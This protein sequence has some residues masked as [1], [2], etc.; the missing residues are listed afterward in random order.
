MDRDV[1]VKKFAD[2]T[3]DGHT[4]LFLGAGSSID[5]GYPSWDILF[6]PLFDKLKISEETN[7]SYYDIAQ[8]YANEFG[9][10]QL[11]KII[12][13]S[14]NSYNYRSPL[15][16]ELLNIDFNNIWTTNFDNV[17]ESNYRTRN[18]DVNVISRD[19]NLVNLNLNQKLNI[20][21][22]NGDIN[23]L[24]EI[25]STRSEYERYKELHELMIMF[26]KK[27]LISNTMLFLGYSFTDNLVIECIA[28]L[29][30]CVGNSMM[31]HYTIMKDLK[32]PL[33]NHFIDD[34]NKRYN[35]Q[36]ILVE[37]YEDIPNV[38]ADLNATIQSKKIFISGAYNLN[39]INKDKNI[40]VDF[41]HKLSNELSKQLL[42]EDYRI[43]NGI[44]RSFGTQL[45]GYANEYLLKHFKGNDGKRL[46]INPFV[47]N[48]K[49][50]VAIKNLNRENII[51]KCGVCIFV[52]GDKYDKP[53][54]KSGVMEEFEIARKEKKIIIPIFYE[55]MI[56]ADIWDIVN[57]H[58]TEFYYLENYIGNLRFEKGADIIVKTIIQILSNCNKYSSNNI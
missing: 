35:I 11:K 4:S 49:D 58:K 44:G 12:N 32:T 20:F 16:D 25:I 45:I 26:L 15:H 42:K 30:K 17:I 41:S 27:E 47:S 57:N 50:S 54:S 23:N 38:V 33:F 6:K 43:V 48:D 28:D 10:S 24:D 55:G 37:N 31:K 21:K 13:K 34:L 19:K 36:A 9:Y 2:E 39:N 52:F 53:L 3:L 18:I 40:L 56:S 51:K 8:Y 29:N 1:F 5:A 14:I 7:I 46:I 22:M